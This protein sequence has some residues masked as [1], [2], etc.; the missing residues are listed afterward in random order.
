ML[1]NSLETTLMNYHSKVEMK[2][3][4]KIMIKLPS[5]EHLVCASLLLSAYTFYLILRTML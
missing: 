4:T 1:F 2:F 3:G 5:N